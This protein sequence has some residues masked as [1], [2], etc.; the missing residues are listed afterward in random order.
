MISDPLLRIIDVVVVDDAAVIIIGIFW[1][2][3]GLLSNNL[4]FI[5]IMIC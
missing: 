1:N 5:V 2:I 4:F 3:C